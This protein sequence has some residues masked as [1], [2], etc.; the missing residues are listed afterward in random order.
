MAE[1]FIFVAI[2]VVCVGAT[3]LAGYALGRKHKAKVHISGKLLIDTTGDKDRWTIFFD[4]DL[5]DIEKM[6]QVTLSI[7]K[8]VE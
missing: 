2:T 8:R 3:L 1:S 4:D 5:G 7:E 6:T